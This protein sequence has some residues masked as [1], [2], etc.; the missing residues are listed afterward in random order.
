ML[1]NWCSPF[2]WFRLLQPPQSAT[3]VPPHEAASMEAAPVHHPHMEPP[4][5]PPDRPLST[6][7][8]DLLPEGPKPQLIPAHGPGNTVKPAAMTQA[9]R[10]VNVDISN[11]QHQPPVA[12]TARGPAD[13][14]DQAV[15]SFSTLHRPAADEWSSEAL[16]PVMVPHAWGRIQAQQHD[17]PSF[18]LAAVKDTPQSASAATPWSRVKDTPSE[19]TPLHRG[20][21]PPGLWL[22]L[23]QPSA[24]KPLSVPVQSSAHNTSQALQQRHVANGAGAAP[25]GVDRVYPLGRSH[26][27]FHASPPAPE[28]TLRLSLSD[29]SSTK[30]NKAGQPSPSRGAPPPQQLATPLPTHSATRLLP[31][32]LPNT[33]PAVSKSPA[34]S[35]S[36]SELLPPQQRLHASQ[37]ALA[38]AAVEQLNNPQLQWHH[39][40][41]ATKS[42]PGQAANQDDI[43]SSAAAAA[44][45]ALPVAVA[46]RLAEPHP[47]VS[48]DG[49]LQLVSLGSA[50]G[51]PQQL[52]IVQGHV[53]HV[54]PAAIH[55]DEGHNCRNRAKSGEGAG[56]VDAAQ[57]AH[58]PHDGGAG[59]PYHSPESDRETPPEASTDH[60]AMHGSEPDGD[61]PDDPDPDSTGSDDPA[62]AD[63]LVPHR[64]KQRA[65]T[66]VTVLSAS[67]A[68]SAA[69]WHCQQRHLVGLS[70]E[71][72]RTAQKA[73][74]CVTPKQHKAAYKLGAW[75]RCSL[76]SPLPLI[77]PLNTTGVTICTCCTSQAQN[78]KPCHLAR[79]VYSHMQLSCSCPVL[80]YIERCSSSRR[81]SCL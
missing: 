20:L 42:A 41:A 77:T 61:P 8:S 5:P 13:M 66:Q 35:D 30:S 7:P 14:P 81:F 60:A 27:Q 43:Q 16:T 72:V 47:I 33:V 32:V 40:A 49:G 2:L 9:P 45:A 37:L 55:L 31:K 15:P 65:P 21:L 12:A 11:Q 76:Y 25:L 28:L 4:N 39:P 48:E 80:C 44:T 38:P 23:D 67:H 24:S 58:D 54:E 17:P 73:L 69:R 34:H 53:M 56:H 63:E 71:L 46:A 19:A 75:S 51:P 52:A 22:G 64:Y 3:D 57:Q 29:G 74:S 10:G 18:S 1:N 50:E 78:T 26:D 68:Y 59:V 70:T 62:A 6:W 36:L 79:I